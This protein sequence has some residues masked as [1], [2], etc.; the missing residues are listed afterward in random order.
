MMMKR[1]IL[2]LFCLFGWDT[3]VYSDIMYTLLITIYVVLYIVYYVCG[4][5]ILYIYIHVFQVVWWTMV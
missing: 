1:A 4:W 2:G 5:V 3:L